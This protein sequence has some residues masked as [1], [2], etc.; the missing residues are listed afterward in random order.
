MPSGGGRVTGTPAPAVVWSLGG[1]EVASGDGVEVSS[2][3][4][5]TQTLRITAVQ[6]AQAGQVEVKAASKAGAASS[7][8]PLTVKRI[9]LPSF[10]TLT[11]LRSW[12]PNGSFGCSHR[13][14]GMCA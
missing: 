4:D 8:A 3:A 11:Q 14:K 1:V 13:L 10:T 2:A 5:G 7:T 12:L 9:T 6:L